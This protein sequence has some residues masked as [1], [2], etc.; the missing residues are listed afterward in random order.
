MKEALINSQVYILKSTFAAVISI[1]ITNFVGIDDPLSSSFVSLL[2][3]KP[4]FYTGLKAGKEQ[5]IASLYGGLITGALILLLGKSITVTTISL[6]IVISLCVFKKWFDYIAVAG[7]TVLYMFLVPHETVQGVIERMVAVFIGIAV[8]SLINFLLSF[9]RYKNF[10][11]F[12][13]KYASNIV[14]QTFQETIEANKK[15]DINKLNE[16]YLDYES[17]YSQLC[18]FTNELSDINKELKIRKKAGGISIDDIEDL[19]RIIENFKMCVR[20]LQDIVYISK[21]LAPEHNKIPLEWKIKIDEFWD[22][23]DRRFKNILDKVLVDKQEEIEISGNYDI[24][25]VNKII[26]T[27]KQESRDKKDIYTKVIS[28]FNDFQQLHFTL[29]NLDY[30]INE[31]TLS[32]YQSAKS[33]SNTNL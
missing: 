20:Y 9:V 25:F 27:I 16:L 14:Y 31:Y 4:T 8:A 33:I 18:N 7:F 21:T 30:F 19:Y 6:L 17:I 11:N 26:N 2:C 10:F 12:R 15:A 24:E 3:I 23:V 28:I 29:N 1:L 32:N 22:I 13:I 5:F